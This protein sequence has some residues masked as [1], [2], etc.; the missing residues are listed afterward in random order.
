[1]AI[2]RG[3]ISAAGD[4]YSIF[5]DA[6][7]RIGAETAAEA[8]EKAVALFPF[9]NP[10]LYAEKRREHMESCPEEPSPL[11]KSHPFV[12][13]DCVCGEKLYFKF[14][15]DYIIANREAVNLDE[16]FAE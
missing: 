7:R 10:H 12:A 11:S 14:L 16:L 13:L 15:C 5:I 4:L 2:P 3:T 6:C 8:L 9:K 1:M